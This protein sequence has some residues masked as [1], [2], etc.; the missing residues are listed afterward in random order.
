MPVRAALPRLLPLLLLMLCAPPAPACDSDADCGVGGTCIK[1]EKRASGVCYGGHGGAPAGDS[2]PAEE[3]PSKPLSAERRR[4]AE[5]WFGDPEEALHEQ[6]P[7]KVVGAVCT[8]TQD[9][10]AGFECVIAGFEG[11]CVQQ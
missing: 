5:H 7:G 10:P 8:V 4:N 11:H 6:L 2:A 3:V 9:C 1:R